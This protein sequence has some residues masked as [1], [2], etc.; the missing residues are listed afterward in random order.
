MNQDERETRGRKRILEH[1]RKTR[2]VIETCRYFGVARSTFYLLNLP[3]ERQD[4][5]QWSNVTDSY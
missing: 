1:A 2:N 4:L 3:V 5:L